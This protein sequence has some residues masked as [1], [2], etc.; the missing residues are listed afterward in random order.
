MRMAGRVPTATA[1]IDSAERKDEEEVMAKKQLL[2]LL[3]VCMFLEGCAGSPPVSLRSISEIDEKGTVVDVPPDWRSQFQRWA[4]V[5]LN[6]QPPVDE[7]VLFETK[8]PGGGFGGCI[9]ILR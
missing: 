4:E 3:L 7:L 9:E 6:Q 8:F 2:R 1:I 5:N